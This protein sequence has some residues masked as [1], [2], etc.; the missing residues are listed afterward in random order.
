M[1]GNTIYTL[2]NIIY[3]ELH[4]L[5]HQKWTQK[6]NTNN[7]NNIGRYFFNVSLYHMIRKEQ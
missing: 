4:T 5:V 7:I 2:N 1:S 3:K 6:G